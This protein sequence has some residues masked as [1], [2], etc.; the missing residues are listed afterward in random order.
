MG[1]FI[2]EVTYIGN[3]GIAEVNVSFSV[4]CAADYY[5]QDCLNFSPNFVSCTGCGLSGFTGEFCQLV[6]DDCDETNCNSN[7]RCGILNGHTVCNHCND[8]FIGN[9]C[10]NRDH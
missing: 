10:E 3:A 9:C 7:G 5:A 8:G 6:T 4:K 2:P 1:T